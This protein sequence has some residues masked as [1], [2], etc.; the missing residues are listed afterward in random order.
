MAAVIAGA[1]QAALFAVKA[2]KHDAALW[3]VALE[4]V[5]E[6][7]HTRGAA[8]IIIGAIKNDIL[9]RRRRWPH[10]DMVIM[11]RNHNSRCLQRWICSAENAD[12]VADLG[13][14]C[15]IAARANFRGLEVAVIPSGLEACSAAL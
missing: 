4:C 10:P 7:N 13:H 6:L 14:G 3:L 5:R 12:D 2:H 1:Q 11:P 15:I 8:G 9:A